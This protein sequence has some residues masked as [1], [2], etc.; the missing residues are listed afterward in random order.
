M[1]WQQYVDKRLT[2]GCKEAGI[3]DLQGNPWAY[4][5]GFAVRLLTLVA[6]PPSSSSEPPPRAVDAGAN[7][8][9]EDRL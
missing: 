4:S 7:R 8:R 1:S 5:P 2:E 6:L 3:Y 9:G